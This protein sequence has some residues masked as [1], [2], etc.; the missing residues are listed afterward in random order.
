[1]RKEQII[2]ITGNETIIGAGV[3]V[4]GNLTSE[5]DMIIDGI[6]VGNVKT[7]GALQVGVNAVIKG[8]LVA[9]DVTISGQ[10]EGDVKAANQAA[11]TETGRVRGNIACHEIAIAAG[12]IFLGTNVMTMVEP[13]QQVADEEPTP[14]P[15]EE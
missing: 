10:L 8:N 9:K 7:K 2:G 5:H 14:T 3:R 6:L 13:A 15:S 12:A 4:R 11:I 1:M